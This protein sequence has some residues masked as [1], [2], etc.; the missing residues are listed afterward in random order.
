MPN[1]DEDVVGTPGLEDHP[2]SHVE[3][4]TIEYL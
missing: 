2:L 1:G 4:N 3:E